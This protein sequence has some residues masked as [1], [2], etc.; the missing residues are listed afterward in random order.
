MISASTWPTAREDSRNLLSRPLAQTNLLV[1]MAT[2][3]RW[4][5]G[6]SFSFMT[7]NLG[8]NS[9]G[10]IPYAHG[11][12]VTWDGPSTHHRDGVDYPNLLSRQLATGT[13][14]LE[15]RTNSTWDNINYR[16]YAPGTI[17]E[18]FTASSTTKY[19]P[20]LD[21]ASIRLGSATVQGHLSG[22]DTITSQKLVAGATFSRSYQAPTEKGN[23]QAIRELVLKFNGSSPADLRDALAGVLVELTFD[24][25]MTARVPVGQ[26]F[27][28]DWSENSRNADNPGS[29]YYR[30]VASDGTLSG[31]SC[32]TNTRPPYV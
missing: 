21:T 13:G 7:P 8:G 3:T 24:G 30:T 17:V 14:N 32:L 1:G 2:R 19:A 16:K 11:I 12:K 5:F 26:F 28:N 6:E 15:Q 9:Y 22:I 23:G 4:G 29:D 10:P 27:G 18:D 25:Q 20:E 31:G